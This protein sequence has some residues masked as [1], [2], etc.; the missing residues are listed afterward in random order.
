MSTSEIIETLKAMAEISGARV[1]PAAAVMMAEDLMR[2]PAQQVLGALR[3]CRLEIKRFP[4]I[5]EIIERLDDGRPGIEQAWALCPMTEDSSAC[6]TE[7][8][9]KAFYEAAL[10]LI[11][12]GDPIAARMSFKEKYSQL[13]VTARSNGVPTKWT[14]TL[15]HDK[16]GQERVLR[17]A[18]ESGRLGVDEARR[19]LPDCSFAA[20][21]QGPQLVGP[22]SVGALVDQKLKALEDKSR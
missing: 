8:V 21:R 1:S 7:E 22:Q 18:V 4:T 3:R 15:G 6:W 11:C 9:S 19:L 10:P 20:S 13:L 5:A 2:F 14:V 17:K 12:N 16:A